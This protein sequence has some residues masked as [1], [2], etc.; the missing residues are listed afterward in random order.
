MQKSILIFCLIISLCCCKAMQNRADNESLY[1]EMYL[2]AA[3]KTVKGDTV[4]QYFSTAPYYVVI[5]VTDIKTGKTKNLCVEYNSLYSAIKKDSGNAVINEKNRVFKFKSDEALKNVG[6]FHFSQKELKKC[7]K[8][9]SAEY[10]IEKWKENHM[11]FSNTFS[12]DCQK[13]YAYLLFKHGVMSYRGS[14]TS[15]LGIDLKSDN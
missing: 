7:T 15:G 10:L 1:Y 12:G 6:F 2:K 14:V 13:Y 5:S 4:F 9:I 3:R 11:N 8:N